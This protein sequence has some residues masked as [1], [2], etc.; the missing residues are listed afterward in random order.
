MLRVLFIVG[1]F[2]TVGTIRAEG[3]ERL[4]V[5]KVTASPIL[6]HGIDVNKMPAHIQS[7]TAEQLEAAQSLSLADYMNQHMGSVFVNETQNNPL[8][9]DVYYRGFSASPLLGLPQGL[10]V[11]LNGVR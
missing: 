3:V 4:A 10:S 7:V 2:I 5:M 11:Y 8:Q 1:L 6:S 9:P